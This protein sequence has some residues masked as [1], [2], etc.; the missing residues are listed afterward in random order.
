MGLLLLLAQA[1]LPVLQ[2][3]PATPPAIEALPPADWS[4]LSDLHFRRRPPAAPEMSQFVKAEVAAGRCAASRQSDGQLILRIDLAV[5]SSPGGQV[6]RIVPRA[7]DC[8]TVEQ[9]AAGLVSRMA[10]DNIDTGGAI[11]EQWYRVGMTFA[12]T[13]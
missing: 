3:V 10:R 8:P 5:R 9:F 7:I 6:R 12:W 2:A 11:G 4:M 1:A 13:E